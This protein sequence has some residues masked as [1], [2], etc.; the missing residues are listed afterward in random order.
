METK[1]QSTQSDVVNPDAAA[2]SAELKSERVQEEL[3][4]EPDPVWMW[5]KSERVQEPTE[6]SAVRVERQAHVCELAFSHQQPMTIELIEPQIVIHVYESTCGK[7][8]AA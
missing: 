6:L 7:R 4:A 5:L 2:L 8:T 3:V 1:Q